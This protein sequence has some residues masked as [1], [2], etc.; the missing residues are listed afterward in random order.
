MNFLSVVAIIGSAAISSFL[1]WLFLKLQTSKASPLR[2]SNEQL[3]RDITREYIR[4]YIA[5]SDF[6]EYI[7]SIIS[8]GTGSET[9]FIRREIE[10]EVYRLFHRKE[11]GLPIEEPD[12]I[13]DIHSN[14]ILDQSTYALGEVT[15]SPQFGRTKQARPNPSSF[16][17]IATVK[18]TQKSREEI[19]VGK[20]VAAVFSPSSQG[21]YWIV[22]PDNQR[23]YIILKDKAILNANNLKTLKILYDFVDQPK[24][25]TLRRQYNVTAEVKPLDG[26]KWELVCCGK[27]TFV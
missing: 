1:I 18:M 7:K 6:R 20:N 27:L 21:D 12:A 19:W 13:N 5:T 2:S 26:N 25:S 24:L 4:S 9:D 3:T 15:S 10:A 14:Q 17:R 11:L 23:Y 16:S 22:S 8:S